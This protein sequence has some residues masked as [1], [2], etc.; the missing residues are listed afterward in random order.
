MHSGAWRG[1]DITKNKKQQVLQTWY[2]TYKTKLEKML[3][4][5][6][7]QQNLSGCSQNTF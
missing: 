2:M 1:I 3:L 5:Q 4:L 6:P 7:F